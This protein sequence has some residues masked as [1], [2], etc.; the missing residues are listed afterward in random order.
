[1]VL[2]LM[3][4]PT[5]GG[6]LQMALSRTREFDADLGAVML[7]GDPDGLA[8]ALHRLER[9]QGRLWE[10]LMLPG[11]RVPNPSVLR[12]HPATEQR[13]QRLM[14]LKTPPGGRD[15]ISFPADRG[16]GRP[17]PRPS[18]MPRIG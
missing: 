13:I 16:T 10:G 15:R 17:L 14:A 9:H 5:L 8:S 7:T 3:A 1:A 12:T 11:G 2:V 18:L 6:L 4:A